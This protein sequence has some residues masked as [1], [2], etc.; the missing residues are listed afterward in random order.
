MSESGD[1]M[2]TEEFGRLDARAGSTTPGADAQSW[3]RE[4]GFRET[5]VKPLVGPDAMVVGIK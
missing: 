4:A 1:G 2:T 5:W 3:L